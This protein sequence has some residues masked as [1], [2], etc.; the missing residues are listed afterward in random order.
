VSAVIT[1]GASDFEV[2]SSLAN[3]KAWAWGVGVT[4]MGS[5][6]LYA[7]YKCE[8]HTYVLGL[9]ASGIIFHDLDMI[10]DPLVPVKLASGS[11]GV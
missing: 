10:A 1:S 6:Q 2:T 4:L 7:R 11:L 3:A 9:F 5:V 8:P